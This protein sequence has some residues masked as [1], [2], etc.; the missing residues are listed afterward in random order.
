MGVTAAD[1]D[2][3]GDLDLLVCNLGNEAD[4]FHRNDGAYF[5]DATAVAGLA[6]LSRPFTRFGMGWYDFDN[7]GHLDLYQANGRVM[8]KSRRYAPDDAYAEPNLLLRGSP[9]PRFSEVLP[10]GGT[11]A[12]AFHTSRA[13]A[14]GDLDGDGGIDVL[15]VNRD[16]APYLLRNVHPSRGNW[17]SFRLI[18]R[19]G[20]DALNASI[21]FGIGER[22]MTRDV[23]VASS[24]LA[25]NDPRIHVGLGD[26]TGVRDL[27]VRWPD[28]TTEAIGAFD[29]NRVHVIRQK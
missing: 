29:A 6:A 15:V 19:D 23:R 20:R 5:S 16:A 21:R 13:A 7:D 18:D 22:V 8:A 17:I 26:A 2:D 25:S 3:D 4:S 28:G 1:I 14:F 11:A 10:R 9:G 24:Y 12:P 27:N